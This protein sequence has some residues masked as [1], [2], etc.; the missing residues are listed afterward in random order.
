[1]LGGG[2]TKMERMVC[3]EVG[4]LRWSEWCDDEQKVDFSGE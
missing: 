4:R 3:W 1:M 2:Q